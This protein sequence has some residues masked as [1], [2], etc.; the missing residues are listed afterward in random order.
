MSLWLRLG[1]GLRAKKGLPGQFLRSTLNISYDYHKAANAG[2]NASA[3]PSLK[4]TF[5]NAVCDETP[6]TS[7]CFGTLVY[8]PTWNG[9]G[10]T[11]GTPGSTNPATDSWT[12]VNIDENTGLFW[13]TGGFGEPNTAGGPPIKTLA[14]WSSIFTPDFG[15]ATLFQVSIGVGS[16]NQGQI[17]YFDNVNISLGGFNDSYDFEPPVVFETVGECISTLTADNCSDLRGSARAMCNH[18]Q[19]MACFDLFGIE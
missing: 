3:A 11:P 10:S 14:G 19:Q 17:G 9:P 2:Q 18:D 5:F 4:L 16:S 12:T 6:I 1:C 15:D 7:R 8:E 13:W